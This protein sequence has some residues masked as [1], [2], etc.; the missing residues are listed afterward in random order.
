LTSKLPRSRAAGVKKVIIDAS[1]EPISDTKY[2][3][4]V[5]STDDQK[6]LKQLLTK[7]SNWC[8]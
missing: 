1:I 3:I 2:R 7:S 8:E 6:Q 4:I 5:A